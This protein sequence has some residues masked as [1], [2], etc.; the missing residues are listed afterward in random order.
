MSFS[1]IQ[2]AQLLQ[3]HPQGPEI[4]RYVVYGEQEDVIPWRPRAETDTHEGSVLQVKRATG[5]LKQAIVQRYF[6][7]GGGVYRRKMDGDLGVNVLYECIGMGR[8]GGPE[9]GMTL[10]QAL[11]RT[12][13][14]WNGDF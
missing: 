2:D 8:V 12:T 9:G 5:L 1:W 3:K 13:Q 4:E 6:T 11:K 7:P 14:G 10:D